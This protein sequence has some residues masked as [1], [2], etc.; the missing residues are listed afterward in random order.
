MVDARL[1][2]ND[3]NDSDLSGLDDDDDISGGGWSDDDDLDSD[4]EFDDQVVSDSADIGIGATDEHAK[5]SNYTSSHQ[6][7]PLA[8]RSEGQHIANHNGE[9]SESGNPNFQGLPPNQIPL[10]PIPR[11][12][13]EN[14]APPPPPPP[15]SIQQ[16]QQPMVPGIGANAEFSNHG[17]KP[18]QYDAEPDEKLAKLKLEEEREYLL[19]RIEEIKQTKPLDDDLV[20]DETTTGIIPTRKRFVSRSQM[21]GFNT[22]SKIRQSAMS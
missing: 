17:S 13:D 21:L 10:P 2:G 22:L 18:P 12:E 6:N 15:I 14:K 4:L 1:S 7:A 3:L 20:D 8:G 5:G 9:Q 16:R 11:K 19:K